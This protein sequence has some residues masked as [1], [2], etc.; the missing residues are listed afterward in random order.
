MSIVF[1]QRALLAASLLAP[2]GLPR[3]SAPDGAQ[4]RHGVEASGGGAGHY[5][6]QNGQPEAA[7]AGRPE[8]VTQTGHASKVDAMAF[9]ASG[10]LF[11]SG[12]ADNTVKMWD[13]ASGRE[14][15]TF[16][17]HRAGVAALSFS[18]DGK[19][20]ASGGNDKSVKVWDVNSGAVRYELPSLPA[21]IKSIALSPEGKWA[22][23]GDAANTVSLW[24]FSSQGGPRPLGKHLGW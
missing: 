8:L 11:A 13:V 23:L 16:A 18:R 1:L 17:G 6:G 10:A 14:L 9:D 7:P 20:V 24:D 19:S 2:A 5:G 22:A 4:G 21:A 15:R 3:H 12:S